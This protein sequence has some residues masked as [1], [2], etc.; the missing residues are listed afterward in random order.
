MGASY[1]LPGAPPAS[2]GCWAVARPAATST[3]L[4]TLVPSTASRMNGRLVRFMLTPWGGAGT[5]GD[6]CFDATA[7]FAGS[8]GLGHRDGLLRNALRPLRFRAWPMRAVIRALL[9]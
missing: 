7:D 5:R 3:R 4:T 2:R 8:G 9:P 6:G 1:P